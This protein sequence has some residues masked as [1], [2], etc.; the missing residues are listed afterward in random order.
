MRAHVTY[1]H[2]GFP[3]VLFC[4]GFPPEL[5]YIGL[6]FVDELRLAMNACTPL[7]RL[8]LCYARIKKRL[9]SMP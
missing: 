8:L 2:K 5:L 3:A 9:S 7:V 6:L 1:W 4:G